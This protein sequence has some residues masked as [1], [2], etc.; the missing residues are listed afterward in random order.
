MGP[1]DVYETLIDGLIKSAGDR[2][3]FEIDEKQVLIA[4][5]T[6]VGSSLNAHEIWESISKQL[7]RRIVRQDYIVQWDMFRRVVKL[8]KLPTIQELESTCELYQSVT[9]TEIERRILA[10]SGIEFEIFLASILTRL[11]QF[12]EIATTQQS[13]DEGV[14]LKGIYV[15]GP[16]SPHFALIGQ[17]KRVTSAVTASQA[18]DFIGAL[19][20]SAER[21]LV[22]LFVSTGGFT[23]PARDALDKCNIRIM[24]WDMVT[25]IEHSKELTTKKVELSFGVP[26]NTFWDEILGRS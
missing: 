22:G 13:H 16:D 19:H 9:P 1:D 23:Q 26:D 6:I 25:L 11:P 5:G 2:D 17:A 4:I 3:R 24:R 8:W 15:P 21:G 7:L 20:L 18:R 14:D 10:L 12:R